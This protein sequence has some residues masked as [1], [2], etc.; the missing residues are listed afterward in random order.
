MKLLPT[1]CCFPL[2]SI[3]SPW[4]EAPLPQWKMHSADT[5]VIERHQ[6]CTLVGSG[7]TAT[8]VCKGKP[9]EIILHLLLLQHGLCLHSTYVTDHGLGLYIFYFPGSASQNPLSLSMLG[10]RDPMPPMHE[11]FRERG[12]GNKVKSKCFPLA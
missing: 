1:P 12:R 7:I 2:S 8:R 11:D 10:L 5:D 4:T 6:K 3:N 9:V